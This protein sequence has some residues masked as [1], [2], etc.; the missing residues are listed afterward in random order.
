MALV[1]QQAISH[2]PE[3]QLLFRFDAQF[4]LNAVDGGPDRL[5]LVTP[6]L[7]DLCVRQT[8]SKQRKDLTLS[9]R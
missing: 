1:I 4:V 9:L 8:L 6:H 7:C 2:R 5:R 3:H